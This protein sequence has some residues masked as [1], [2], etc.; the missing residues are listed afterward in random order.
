M[1]LIPRSRESVM[2]TPSSPVPV[3]GAGSAGIAAASEAGLGATIA[4]VGQSL[5]QHAQR[6]QDMAESNSFEISAAKIR[7]SYTTSF[8][9]AEK[10]AAPDGS[11]FVQK[12]N[13]ISAP[14]VEEIKSQGPTSRQYVDRLNAVNE[15]MHVEMQ[16]HATVKSISMLESYNVNGAEKVSDTFADS[17]RQ[18]PDPAMVDAN[19][20]MYGQYLDEKVQK[21]IF[22]PAHREKLWN[23]FQEK[24]GLSYLYGLEE[25]GQYGKALNYLT[26]NAKDPTLTNQL[27][28]DDAYDLRLIDKKE[29]TALKGQGKTYDVP[30]LTAHDGA[31]LT[32]SMAAT[33]NA[34]DP[35]KKAAMIDGFKGKAEAANNL[36]LSEL[37]SNIQSFEML[38]YHGNAP[39]D[40]QVATIKAQINMNPSVT[41]FARVRNMDRVN[42][43]NI[44]SQ[45]IKQ[46]EISPRSKWGAVLNSFDGRVDMANKHAAGFDPQ[47]GNANADITVQ[48]NRMQAKEQ[49]QAYMDKLTKIQSNDA[50][51]FSVDSDPVLENLYK[52]TKDND[53][54]ASQKFA[55]QTMSRQSFLQIPGDDQSILP[56]KDAQGMGAALK[57]MPNSEA[58]DDFLKGLQRKWGPYYPKV[59]AEI[60][61]TDKTIEK[62]QTITYAPSGS[63]FDLVDA[64]KNQDVIK[65]N[66][67]VIPNKDQYQKLLNQAVDSRMR[68]FAQSISG[69]ANDSSRLG[70]VN[71]FRESIMLQ[72][73]RDFLRGNQTADSIDGIADK[74]YNDIV[75]QQYN[76]V[77]S[78]NSAVIAPKT[79]LGQ[80]LL[81]E[82]ISSYMQKYST[83][84][85]LKELGVL[86]PKDP[87]GK[88]ERDPES[89]YSDLKATGRWVTNQNQDGIKLMTVNMDGSLTPVYDKY[90]KPLEKKFNQVLQDSAAYEGQRKAME[91]QQVKKYAPGAPGGG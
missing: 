16:S 81:P 42:T 8:A 28:P 62:Y 67:D 40:Q 18:N 4:S 43:A 25:R 85:G 33:M 32:P 41:P 30:V 52:G 12:F 64:V 80:P 35:L 21:N 91:R 24:Q 29:A 53:P 20:K 74:A 15:G 84:E 23:T 5:I 31:Q 36:K 14:Q 34:I 61:A 73:K 3:R 87:L 72:A 58:A 59:L 71:N 89:F 1:S 78:K 2:M 60:S 65:K 68:G 38:A 54:D 50:G 11:D 86:T 45:T 76:V 13:D 56:N 6:Q 51:Q 44:A 10:E 75:G 77:Q 55:R 63:R 46:L 37:N 90:G 83:P 7:A 26:A 17:I 79:F 48:A 82:Q 27:D 19:N 57:N 70:V 39:T 69:S 66:F 22:S 49:V 9:R 88:Y 47:M